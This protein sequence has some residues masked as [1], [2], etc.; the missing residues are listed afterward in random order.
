MG[1]SLQTK[2]FIQECVIVKVILYFVVYHLKARKTQFYNCAIETH[3][4]KHC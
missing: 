1:N 4:I 2:N 3:N